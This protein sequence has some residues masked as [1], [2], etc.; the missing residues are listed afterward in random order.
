[1]STLRQKENPIFIAPGSLNTE[2]P[3][4]PQPTTTTTPQ[5]EEIGLTHVLTRDDDDACNACSSSFSVDDDDD[6]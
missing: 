1:L 5:T 6:D 2:L 4:Q 3:P